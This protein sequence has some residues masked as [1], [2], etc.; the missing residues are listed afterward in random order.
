MTLLHALRALLRWRGLLLRLE[1]SSSRHEVED[2]HDDGKDQKD[3]YPPAKGVAADKSNE[4]EDEKNNGYCPKHFVL[5]DDC[6]FLI[7]P[8]R[9]DGI[10]LLR[11]FL[12]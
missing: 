4:P 7:S 9:N 3:M 5:L 8:V 6:R 1:R 11:P 10:Q 12:W 2:E